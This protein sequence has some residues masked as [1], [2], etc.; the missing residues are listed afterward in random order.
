MSGMETLTVYDRRTHTYSLKPS[1]AQN[2]NLMKEAIQL[3]KEL[4][5]RPRMKQVKQGIVSFQNPETQPFEV[6]GKDKTTADKY[7]KYFIYS[8]NSTKLNNKPS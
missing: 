5:D 7:E 4:S 2:N 3:A 8:I 6:V 1:V